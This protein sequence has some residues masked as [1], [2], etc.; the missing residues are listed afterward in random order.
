[1]NKSKNIADFVFS[2]FAVAAWFTIGYVSLWALEKVLARLIST[3]LGP[4]IADLGGYFTGL[5][6]LSGALLCV[7]NSMLTMLAVDGTFKWFGHSWSGSASET[8]RRLLVQ[9]E[10]DAASD[11]R[12]KIPCAR[13]IV[14]AS[15][16][17][18]V[19]LCLAIPFESIL[20]LSGMEID[21][22]FVYMPGQ[23]S[24]RVRSWIITTRSASVRRFD[25]SSETG[26]GTSCS[27]LAWV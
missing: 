1:M 17:F 27:P 2:R 19:F 8:R 4:P 21:V 10:G 15:T 26:L 20:I 23:R 12:V 3:R 5:N 13:P 24:K 9:S 16:W 11:E 6:M 18:F 14:R 25:S 7:L 22:G